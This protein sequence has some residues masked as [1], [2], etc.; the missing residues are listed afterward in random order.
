MLFKI[1]LKIVAIVID[2]IILVIEIID[3]LHKQQEPH[4]SG[5]G[6]FNV[7]QKNVFAIA[8]IIIAPNLLYVNN[9]QIFFL[10]FKKSFA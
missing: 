2:T 8:K 5:H 4:V 6:V 1:I 9:F 3:D 10:F 7:I